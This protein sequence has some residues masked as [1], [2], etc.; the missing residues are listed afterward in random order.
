M[1]HYNKMSVKLSNLQLNKLKSVVKNTTEVTLRLS[2]NLIAND[3]NDFLHKLLITDRQ[4]LNL[5]E[6][7]QI[8]HPLM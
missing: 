2:S 8:I 4:V 6:L 5:C 3:E 1:T 7:L